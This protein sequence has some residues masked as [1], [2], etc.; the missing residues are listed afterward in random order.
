MLYPIY[1]AA[2]KTPLYVKNS[3]W[4]ASRARNMVKFDSNIAWH[5]AMKKPGHQKVPG[6]QFHTLAQSAKV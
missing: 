4:R 6:F 5:T 2:P 1:H 3:R